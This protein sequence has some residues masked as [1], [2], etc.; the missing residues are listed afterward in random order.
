MK[1][2][3]AKL[4]TIGAA[5]AVASSV[6]NASDKDLLD[7]LLENGTLNP[8]QYNK[9]IKQVEAKEA[10]EAATAKSASKSDWTS[11]I[12][13]GGDMR[14]RFESVDNS[15]KIKKHRQRIRARLKIDAKVND[16]VKAGMRL[17][18]SGGRTSTNKSLG[19]TDDGDHGFAGKAVYFDRAFITWTPKFA[20]GASATAG[21][22][23]MPWYRVTD[24]VWD[25][26][27]NPEGLSLSYTNNI[28]PAELTA[29]GGYYILSDNG[30]E[31][32]TF[33][34]D[35]NMYHAGISAAMKFSDMIKASIG[36]NAFLFNANDPVGVNDFAGDRHNGDPDAD[37]KI[38][39]VAGKVEID[40]GFV[41]VKVYGNIATNEAAQDGEDTA[42]L[43]GIGTKW[44]SFKLEYNY[45][46]TQKN[47]VT[48]TFNDSDFARGATGARG[49][50]VK[51]S[52]E[53]SK[54]F[55][56]GGAYLGAEDYTAVPGE[57]IDIDTFQLD[58]KAKF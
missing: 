31:G 23:A 11:K 51:L 35:L 28:G 21:K 2:K 12:K 50:K 42:W 9:L 48:D 46:D 45:R 33:G 10:E 41:P 20:H 43:A 1:C 36:G 13:I 47:A 34:E 16:E 8:T 30:D 44:N 37:F 53:I 49:H 55:S 4:L 19:D 5:A 25:S 27:V 29:T 39:E 32:H 54:H 15:E 57:N 3:T 6:V 24:N 14:A 58:V 40:T 52:Y 26:D 18:T 22:F 56:V 17:V 38:Y 7:I